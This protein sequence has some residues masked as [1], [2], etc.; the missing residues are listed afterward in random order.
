M[1][2]W[3][4][5]ITT[6]RWR[7]GLRVLGVILLLIAIA[8]FF[9][10]PP[11]RTWTIEPVRSLSGSNFELSKPLGQ[12]AHYKK[13][14]G[15]K[16]IGLVFYG[17]RD[18]VSILDC[19][20]KNNLVENGGYLDEARFLAR[21]S[22]VDDLAWLDKLVL[23]SS[24]YSRV[25]VSAFGPGVDYISAWQVVND[26][27]MYIKI[28]DDVV[29]IEDDAIPSMVTTLMTHPE[30]LVVSANSINQPALSWIHHH[31]GAV[32]PY[33]PEQSPPPPDPHHPQSSSWRAS[34]L[35]VWQ[36]DPTTFPYNVSFPAPFN[37]HR[38]LPLPA[39]STTDHTPIS[40][41]EY[42]PA[43]P[44]WH[45][46][47]VGAQ[48]H[49]SFFQNL[50]RDELWRYKFGVWDY[51]YERLSI[52]L[53]AMWGRDV[54]DAQPFPPDDEGFLTVDLPRRLGRH[55][56]LDGNAVSVHYAFN[57]QQGDGQQ[58]LWTDALDRYR[59]YAEENICRRR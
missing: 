2:L 35:P 40:R 4:T 59:A 41:V 52:Q 45:S 15:F 39:N 34:E 6:S 18:R 51:H 23:T 57:A 36:G 28:D 30:Y 31:L 20:L 58:M 26:E 50:E 29:Y 14:D 8:N 24:G 10:E 42:G 55:T 56:V 43:A 9:Y 11:G 37:G 48:Q 54:M 13:P 33:L 25:N 53:V 5:Q 19:Y 12:Q 16:I 47:E 44:G 3:D 1:P 38:W 21:T 49:Y 22:D 32:H 7:L 46:W 27:N 17:R